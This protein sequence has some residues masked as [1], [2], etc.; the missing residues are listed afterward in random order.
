M[1]T[2]HIISPTF[3]GL[4]RRWLR[5]SGL[6]R[7]L[8]R[9]LLQSPLPCGVPS[10][11]A[12]PL[13]RGVGVGLRVFWWLAGV[14]FW[15]RLFWSCAIGTRTLLRLARKK[16]SVL[17]APDSVQK[18]LADS[19]SVLSEVDWDGDQDL[20]LLLGDANGKVRFFEKLANGT[21]EERLGASNP[22]S[23][24]PQPTPYGQD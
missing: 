24:A 19:L 22:F 3:C 16:K 4:S 12:R 18:C 15:P 1:C 11:L 20:D 9:R 5:G 10:G 21:L 8:V 6:V 17:Y 23:R 14:V 7:A 2:V 13:F